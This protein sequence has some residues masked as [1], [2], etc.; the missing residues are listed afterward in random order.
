MPPFPPSSQMHINQANFSENHDLICALEA[1]QVASA[2]AIP[3]SSRAPPAQSS[4]T[5]NF[6]LLL[7]VT[8]PR[9]SMRPILKH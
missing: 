5:N 2:R 8:D 1:L 9:E 4:D 7:M 6:K 3:S